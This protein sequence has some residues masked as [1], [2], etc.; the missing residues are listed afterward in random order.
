MSLQPP[1]YYRTQ[2]EELNT[3]YTISLQAVL[4]LMPDYKLNAQIDD[5][6]QSLFLLHQNN[7]TKRK[8]EI[9]NLKTNVENDSTKLEE[10]I[11]RKNAAIALE[12]TQNA[13]LKAAYQQLLT[14]DNG[15]KGALFDTQ[16][17]Y[18]QQYIGNLLL[19]SVILFYGKMI[20]SK[21]Y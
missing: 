15:S 8:N 4:K 11:I 7:L 21:Y 2:L 12:N 3:G 5:K 17:L 16:L 19:L 6:T 18:N 20:Y 1:S 9:M 10:Q 13:K 14:T